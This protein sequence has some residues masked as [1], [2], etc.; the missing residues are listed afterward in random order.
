M[1]NRDA[2]LEE[3]RSEYSDE[4]ERLEEEKNNDLDK[5]RTRHNEE[6]RP[7]TDEIFD[8]EEKIEKLSRDLL[9]LRVTEKNIELVYAGEISRRSTQLAFDIKDLSQNE[10]KTIKNIS[11]AESQEISSAIHQRNVDIVSASKIRL[12]DTLRN[13]ADVSLRVAQGIVMVPAK[14]VAGSIMGAFSSG[15]D[16]YE[17]TKNKDTAIRPDSPT[18]IKEETRKHTMATPKIP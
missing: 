13:V 8:I 9:T 14:A 10:N 2:K 1:D 4:R 16:A 18:V 5:L 12:E 3:V 11:N 15:V 17:E 6:I 7:I